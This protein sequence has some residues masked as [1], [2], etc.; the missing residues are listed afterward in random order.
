MNDDDD[1]RL[2]Q[3]FERLREDDARRAPSFESVRKKRARRRSPWAVIVP[4][5]SAVA[6]AAVLV[7][8]CNTTA[9]KPLASTVAASPAAAP[10]G[11]ELAAAPTVDEAPL[12]FLLD[13]PGLRGAPDFDTSLLRGSIR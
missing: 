12:D 13:V 10:L 9:R 7:V 4:F 5:A 1:E 8:W 6:A 11:G 2:R 3:T